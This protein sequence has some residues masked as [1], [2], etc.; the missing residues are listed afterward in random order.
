MSV[1]LEARAMLPA[2]VF[3]LGTDFIQV[4][5]KRPSMSGRRLDQG[6]EILSRQNPG[7]KAIK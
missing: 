5:Y 6:G 1:N 7:D 4:F 2:S 3:P